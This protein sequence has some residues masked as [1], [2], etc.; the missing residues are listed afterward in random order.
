MRTIFAIPQRRLAELAGV[1][2]RELARIEAGTVYPLPETG[3]RIDSALVRLVADKART[4][5]ESPQ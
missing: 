3:R 4:Q 1:S 5:L 2:V